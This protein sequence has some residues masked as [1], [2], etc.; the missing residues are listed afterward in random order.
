MAGGGLMA[1][2]ASPTSERRNNII[3]AISF[4]LEDLDRQG[5]F[6]NQLPLPKQLLTTPLPL[7]HVEIL[8]MVQKKIDMC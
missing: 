3:T 6:Q 5:F 8:Q 7:G 1:G 2:I 4:L